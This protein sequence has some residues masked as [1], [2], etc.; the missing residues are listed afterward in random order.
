MMNKIAIDTNILVYLYD[1]NSHD[2]RHVSE[3][4]V[5]SNPII[6]TQVVSEFINVTR[7]ALKVSKQEVLHKCNS[8]FN[9]C[10]I[11]SVDQDVLD[12]SYYLLKKYDF[13]IFDS[14]VISS[15]LAA[16]CDTLYSE[17]FQ[18][19]QLIEGKLTIINPYLEFQ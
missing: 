3:R 1:A 11:I 15:T 12:H 9:R 14:I 17:D 6:S 19:R 13:Q 7:R 2:K 10:Q 8:V 16:G 4:L 18:H 5:A